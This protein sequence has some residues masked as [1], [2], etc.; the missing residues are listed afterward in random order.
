MNIQ[1]RF[2]CAPSSIA[3]ARHFAAAHLEMLAKSDTDAVLL[4]VS[5]LATNAIRHA[6]SGFTLAI[7]VQDET[8]RVSV[9]DE[10]AGQPVITSP[11]FTQSSGRGLK[12][13]DLLSDRWGVVPACAEH[14]K[15]VWFVMH[16]AHP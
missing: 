14:G 5:E 3:R 2:P 6:S 7:D 13:V 1:Q 4:L 12:I 8:I 15:S 11:P 10:G 16:V 9:E